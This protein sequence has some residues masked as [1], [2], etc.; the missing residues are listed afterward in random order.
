MSNKANMTPV[1]AAEKIIS[2]LGEAKS[3]HIIQVISMSLQHI[4]GVLGF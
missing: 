1:L 4:V 2:L 3:A